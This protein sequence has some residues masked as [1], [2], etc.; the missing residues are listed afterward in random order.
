[1][2][3]MHK[4]RFAKMK[5]EATGSSGDEDDEFL[6]SGHYISGKRF[7]IGEMNRWVGK[8]VCEGAEDRLDQYK[9]TS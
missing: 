2:I 1:M 6:G 9:K 5:S 4:E 8:A 7:N 3:A